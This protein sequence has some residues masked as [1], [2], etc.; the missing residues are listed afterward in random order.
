MTTRRATSNFCCA[1]RL[2]GSIDTMR[3]CSRANSVWVAVSAMFSL[4][5]TSPAT[6]PWV[7]LASSR[8]SA[9]IS[10]AVDASP[11]AVRVGR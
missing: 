9:A 2:F 6:I 1:V 4:A 11:R 10:G 8:P 5:R 7:G 3:L